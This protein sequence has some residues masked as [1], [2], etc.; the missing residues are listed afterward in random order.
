M[1]LGGLC[2]LP[3]CYPCTVSDV[4]LLALGHNFVSSLPVTPAPL[5]SRIRTLR[6]G[7]VFHHNSIAKGATK[8][9]WASSSSRG[10]LHP[11][12]PGC[13]GKGEWIP[14]QQAGAELKLPRGKP[15]PVYSLRKHHG[16]SRLFFVCGKAFLTMLPN[17]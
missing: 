16:K 5:L 13:P 7:W 2:S 14:R 12:V 9:P 11:P 6:S 15:V 4:T 17:S 10:L 1:E 8:V 3:T